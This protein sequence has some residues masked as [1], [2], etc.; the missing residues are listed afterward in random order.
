MGTGGSAHEA[1]PGSTSRMDWAVRVLLVG[2][3]GA[4]R[5]VAASA[6][7]VRLLKWSMVVVLCVVS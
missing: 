1:V 3:A 6:K 7:I 4:A 5:V 2:G